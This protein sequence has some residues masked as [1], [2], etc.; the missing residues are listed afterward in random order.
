MKLAARLFAVVLACSMG[1]ACADTDL[2]NYIANILSPV[3]T[4]GYFYDGSRSIAC[5]WQG[6]LRTALPD[7]PGALNSGSYAVAASGGTAYTAGFYLTSSGS[8]ACYWAGATAPVTLLLPGGASGAMAKGIYVSGSTVLTAGSYYSSG[9]SV[10]CYWNGANRQDLSVPAGY[11]AATDVYAS[12]IASWGGTICTSGRFKDVDASNRSRAVYW[13]GTNGFLLPDGVGATDSYATSICDSEGTVYTAGY[14]S[15]G[16]TIIPCYW[17]GHLSAPVDLPVI[18]SYPAWTSSIAVS[19]GHVY[20]SGYA[21]DGS[22]YVPCYWADGARTML[23]IPSTAGSNNYATG[24]AVSVGTVYTAG[25]YMDG[26][27]NVPCYWVGTTRTDFP[28]RGA[29]SGI[30]NSIFVQ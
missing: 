23:P 22:N 20:V 14:Y 25:Y 1:A 17:V 7:G 10:A 15:D 18:G 30:V 3:Y 5:Y 16:S 13:V 28:A 4:A 29:V 19:D 8:I 24:I 27:D 6:T 9:Q 2:R 21:Y 26:T 12:A 11:T